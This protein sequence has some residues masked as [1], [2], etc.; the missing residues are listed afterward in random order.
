MRLGTCLRIV[1]PLCLVALMAG[2]ATAE[3]CGADRLC[4]FADKGAKEDL[5]W[6]QMP[7]DKSHKEAYASPLVATLVHGREPASVEQPMDGSGG[8]ATATAALDATERLDDRKILQVTHTANQVG[9]DQARLA[10]ARAVDPRV[11]QLAD[12]TLAQR[13]DAERRN[14]D[15]SKARRIEPLAS[16]T[17]DELMAESLDTVDALSEKTGPEFDRAYLDAQIAA[18]RRMLQL[19]DRELVPSANDREVRYLVGQLRPQVRRQLDV[20]TE[21]QQKLKD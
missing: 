18:N 12:A 13:T 7:A 14:R 10:K 11:R 17:S 3:P 19:I 2:A 21:L 6:S 1:S 5:D 8:A 15:V 20:A 4:A 16:Q 9:I